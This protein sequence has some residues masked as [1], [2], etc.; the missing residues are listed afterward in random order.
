LIYAAKGHLKA[1]LHTEK[2]E[3][4]NYEVFNFGSGNG[5]SV[6]QVIKEF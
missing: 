4:S 1:L 5:F 6:M 3:K 2:M